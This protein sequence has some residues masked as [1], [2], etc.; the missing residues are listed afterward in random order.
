MD[1]SVNG[2][3]LELSDTEPEYDIQTQVVE[4]MWNIL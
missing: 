2:I 3:I 1:D 4:E